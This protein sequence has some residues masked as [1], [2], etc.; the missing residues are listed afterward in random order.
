MNDK[1]RQ[2]HRPTTAG[3]EV[4]IRGYFL[5]INVGCN[6]IKCLVLSVLISGYTTSVNKQS[7]R[8]SDELGNIAVHGRRLAMDKK[9]H[10]SGTKVKAVVNKV[11]KV[12]TPHRPGVR[13]YN[14]RDDGGAG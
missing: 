12:K 7:L 10:T 13:N 4:K 6:C 8:L 9:D 2:T 5:V 11:R 1:V 14:L 3:V